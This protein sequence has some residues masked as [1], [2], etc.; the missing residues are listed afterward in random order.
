M[1]N[2]IIEELKWRGLFREGLGN[3]TENLKSGEYFYVGTDPTADSLGVHHLTA[4]MAARVLQKHGLKP[5]ILVGTATA[6]LGDPSGKTEERAKLSMDTVMHNTECI[7]KQLSTILDFDPSHENHAI[8]V[9]NYDW[10]SKF[11]FLDFM[12][13]I[14]KCMTVNYMMAKD[15]VKTRLSREGQGL[16]F[17]EFAYSNIQA[18]DFVHL[19]EEF[20][21][22]I[23]IGGVDQIGNMDS[24][25]TLAHKRNKIDCLSAF[26]WDLI[27]DSTGKKFGKSEGNAVWLDPKK[28]TPY[29][30]YQFWMNQ[31]DA[32]AEKFIKI[33]TL[34]SKEEIEC[35][36]E[37]HRSAPEKRMLQKKLA[38]Y[39]TEMVHGKDALDKAIAASNILF[40]KATA[41]CLTS[42]DEETLLAVMRDVKKIEI[43]KT[44][45]LGQN[46]VDVACTA[47]IGSKSEIRKLINAN[48][49]SLNK[50]KVPS[51]SVT[52]SEAH[53]INGKYVLLQKGKRDYTLAIAL[54]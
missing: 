37:Q 16:S 5:I 22:K 48:G 20:G 38:E 31:S 34:L 7:L 25:F 4:F 30:L 45:L 43:S 46:I 15:S 19:Y 18:F 14:G 23:Q 44:T 26:V 50:T 13:D 47:G 41:E 3:I 29:T 9:N 49:F 40:G 12:R 17:C 39:V 35:L 6:S 24:A 54:S 36:I 21:C 53:L 28:T 8:F 1:K 27:T 42:L 11:S 52:I 51:T 33:F 32:D 10:M 2:Q